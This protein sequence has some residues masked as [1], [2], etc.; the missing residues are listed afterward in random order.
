MI[1]ESL[2]IVD[3]GQ[4]EALIECTMPETDEEIWDKYIPSAAPYVEAE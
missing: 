2:E 4:A 3:L 1:H